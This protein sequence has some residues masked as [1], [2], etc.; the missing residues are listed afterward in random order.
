MHCGIV[1]TR[2]L[3]RTGNNET[4][5][6]VILC[7]EDGTSTL[8]SATH[9]QLG[10]GASIALNCLETG[11]LVLVTVTILGTTRLNKIAESTRTRKE[12]FGYVVLKRDNLTGHNR[13]LLIEFSII[14]KKDSI[15]SRGSNITKIRHG[16]HLTAK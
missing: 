8:N 6:V 9:L 4:F 2:T 14:I 15:P 12:L 7:T 16:L 1:R 13:N 5:F 3:I 11:R 10:I